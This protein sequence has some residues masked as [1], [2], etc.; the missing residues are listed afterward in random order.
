MR[1][2]T[3]NDIIHVNLNQKCVSALLEEK[4]S[5]IYGTHLK[6]LSKQE[7]FQTLISGSRSLFQSIQ[8]F[9]EFVNMVGI[10]GIFKARGLSECPMFGVGN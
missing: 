9:V 4:Q 6:A 2:T 5:F 1:G 10:L 3:K 8:G 7:G